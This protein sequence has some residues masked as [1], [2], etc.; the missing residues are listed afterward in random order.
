MLRPDNWSELMTIA[1]I[2]TTFIRQTPYSGYQSLMKLMKTV[3]CRTFLWCCSAAA[4]VV[5]VLFF[6]PSFSS[7]FSTGLSHLSVSIVAGDVCTQKWLAWHVAM[8]AKNASQW[9]FIV[10]YISCPFPPACVKRTNYTFCGE[11]ERNRVNFPAF[12]I[13][14]WKPS[15]RIQLLD[16]SVLCSYGTRQIQYCRLNVQRLQNL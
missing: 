15:L 5:V 7:Y 1:C 16:N 4:L 6:F 10:W 11:R 9:C 13:W 12:S 8:S 2:I 3:L 14:T